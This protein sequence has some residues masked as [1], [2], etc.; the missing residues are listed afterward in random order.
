V[1]G[2]RNQKGK[3][4]LDCRFNKDNLLLR[5]RRIAKYRNCI[6]LDNQDAVDFM[7]QCEKNL[8]E[9]LFFCIA[10]Y[11]SK[12]SSLYANYYEKEDHKSLA[13][14]ILSLKRPWIL[15]YDDAEE[16]K[17]LYSSRRQFQLNLNYSANVK[18]VGTEILVASKGL[19]IP[20]SFRSNQLHRPQYRAA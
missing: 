13:K 18:R 1:I 7:A 14:T 19:Y 6:H 11:F 4:K 3:Y 10:P 20:A 12:G 5:I 9:E 8:P 2:G 16:I 17:K 15:T